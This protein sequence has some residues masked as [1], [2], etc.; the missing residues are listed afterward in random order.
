MKCHVCNSELDY[1]KGFS[2][3]QIYIIAD[4]YKCPNCEEEFYSQK[5]EEQMEKI[6]LSLGRC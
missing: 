2:Y 4:N 6:D 1:K 3:N 5:A